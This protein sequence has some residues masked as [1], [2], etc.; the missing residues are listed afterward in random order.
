MQQ[1]MLGAQFWSA[2]VPCDAQY[3]DAVQLTLEQINVIRRLVDSYNTHLQ[4]VTSAQGKR[5]FQSIFFFST[6]S[7]WSLGDFVQ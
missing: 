2:Y 7:N 3:K 5:H 6:V 1:G 4:F